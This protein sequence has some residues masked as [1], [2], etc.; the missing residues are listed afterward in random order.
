MEKLKRMIMCAIPMSICNFRCHYCY[1]SHRSAAY[2]G[3]QAKFVYSPEHVR[4]AFS[5]ERLGGACFF[6]FCADGETLLTKQIDEY[7]KA[8]VNE[9]HYIEIVTNMSVRPVI[10]KILMWDAELLKR[11]EFK[12]SFH[13]LEL[14]AKGLLEAFAANINKAWAAGA[15]ASVELTPSDELIPYIDELKAFSMEKFGALPQLTIARD[16]ATSGIEYLTKLP[17]DEYRRVWSQFDSPFWQFKTSIFKQKRKEFCYSGAYS[18]FVNLATGK[19]GQCYR[20]WHHQNI[21]DDLA[22]PIDFVPIGKCKQPHC[23]NGHALLTMGMMPERFTD[24]RFG[25][26]IRDRVRADG[27]HWLNDDLR[28]FFDGRCDEN[29]ERLSGSDERKILI[30]AAINGLL[31]APKRALRGVYQVAKRI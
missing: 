1:L 6:N 21:F 27:T 30:S 28:A 14:K 4:K 7:M 19:T 12:C 13:Y 25:S 15:S 26:D 29:N 22:K 24:I 11:T 17:E 20:S 5:K 8:I 16:D 31:H 2:Q 9:G 18:L 3:E 10:E 23:Y